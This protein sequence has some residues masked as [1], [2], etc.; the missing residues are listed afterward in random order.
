MSKLVARAG[1]KSADVRVYP[2][3]DDDSGSAKAVRVEADGETCRD[4]EF[5][6]LDVSEIA[7]WLILNSADE[8]AREILHNATA[9]AETLR[10]KVLR[11]SA[12]SGREEAMKELIPSLVAFAD[13]GQSLIVFE[14]QL[15][16][17][18][19]PQLVTLALE[20]AEK[21]THKAVQEDPEIVA[22]VLER[23]QHEVRDAK[24]I[25]IC[26]HPQ[27]FQVLKDLRPDLV[28]IGSEAGR[29]VEVF[30]S[31]DIPRGGC[32]LETESGIVDA[33]VPTQIEEIRRQLLDTEL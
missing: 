31:E 4:F 29:S 21:M 8:R 2:D 28:K 3:L 23:A 6:S 15:I 10:Q 5:E 19:T 20:I 22:G 11:E 16:A 14:E 17:R 32:R 13:A 26:L 25:R 18:C 1:V 9:E 30:A 27:D 24:Q 33:T 12:A 7:P